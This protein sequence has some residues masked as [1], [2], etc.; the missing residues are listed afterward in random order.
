MKVIDL[1]AGCGGFSTGF[2][3]G[4]YDVVKAVEFDPMIAQSYKD[5]HKG[6][7]MIVNDIGNIDNINYFCENESDVIIGGPP[8]QGFSMAG[9]RIRGGFIEDPRN[10]LFKHYFNVVKIVK[11]RVFVIENVSG[12]LTM[13]GGAIFKEIINL[14][15]DIQ[16]FSGDRYYLHYLIVNAQD[17]GIPQ[18]RERVIIIGVK[19]RDFDID[20]LFEDTRKTML[21]ENSNFFD[22]VSV[23]D[24]I[25]NMPV[26][27]NDGVCGN[28]VSCSVYQKYLASDSQQ[29]KNNY[30]TKHSK[31]AIERMKKIQPGNNWTSLDEEIH[32]V[33]SG[34]YGRLERDGV[35]PTITTRFDTPSGGCFIHPIFDRTLTAR[36]AARIQ[37]FPDDFIF[38]GNKSS[39]CRQIGNAVPPKLAFF[40]SRAVRRLLEN[41]I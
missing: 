29:L 28:V 33:H 10:Y 18:H 35:A 3:Q 8:C 23:W 7:N 20:K 40:I 6:T 17:F 38:S 19:N 36:E 11:P 25:S 26:P 32:S 41:D 4:G 34:S 15:S 39:V 24:A 1:F 5:N 16:N 21:A 14:F 9:A 27:T 22:K 31:L 2:L 37:S 30:A 13:A 12:I